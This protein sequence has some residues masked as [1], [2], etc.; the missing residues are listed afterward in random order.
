MT[1]STDLFKL[2]KSL[3]KS[4]KRYFKLF[5]G[6]SGERKEN[7]SLKL[8]DAIDDQEDYD[9]ELLKEKFKNETFAKQ[10]AVAKNYL[11]QLIIKSITAYH[12]ESSP[13]MQLYEMLQSL[14]VLHDKGHF[15]ICRKI[16]QKGKELC[17]ANEKPM[18][19]E[20]FLEMES[21][22]L[23]R[24]SDFSSVSDSIDKQVA[25]L[26]DYKLTLDHKKSVFN[27]Y[28]KTAELGVA[29]T[30]EEI[31][32]LNELVESLN[33]QEPKDV[34][35][36]YYL[37]S[38]YNLYYCGIDDHFSM[39]D[40]A[41]KIIALLELNP[42]FIEESP[43]AYL[44]ALNN[45]CSSLTR[46]GEIDKVLQL[47]KKMRAIPEQKVFANK[48]VEILPSLIF[49]YGLE[50][51]CYTSKGQM[52]K[53]LALEVD[54][55]HMLNEYRNDIHKNS[56]FE[57]SFNMALAHFIVGNNDSALSWL[58]D[59]INSYDLQ[60]REDIYLAA[61]ILALIAHYELRNVVL[62]Y[63]LI[64]STHRYLKNKKLLN[65]IES[66]VLQF[67]KA[68]A[69]TDDDTKR[70]KLLELKEKILKYR[71]ETDEGKILHSVDL[72]A[73]VESKLTQKPMSE[74][75]AKNYVNMVS[76]ERKKYLK[77]H[78]TTKSKK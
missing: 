35:G 49:S 56:I 38:F 14:E 4:E 44:S 28:T 53:A 21:K 43:G 63:N 61:R 23:M 67:L 32:T 57:I 17:E 73:W 74:Y 70:E 41:E 45:Y 78:A 1:P 15:N 39:H 34:A 75:L 47:I 40:Y 72:L 55:Q 27:M 37:Y 29:T 24:N 2:I 10:F 59:I 8:F 19:M 54:I 71:H 16:I 6:F 26:D 69:I 62:L 48:K 77:T 36:K 68:T 13:I 5:A 46:F 64:G 11:Q 76:E 50:L 33:P 22:I 30:D 9:E 60:Y 42:F 58:N 51:Y 3:S 66:A 20:R 65:S 52:D 25:T 7:N 31:A 12:N 18:L